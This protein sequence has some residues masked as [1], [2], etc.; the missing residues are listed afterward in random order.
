MAKPSKSANATEAPTSGATEAN[1]AAKLAG[2]VGLLPDQ[3]EFVNLIV[4]HFGVMGELMTLDDALHTYMFEHDEFIAFVSD[5]NVRAALKERDIPVRE[6]SW[7]HLVSV[8][9]ED[10]IVNSE[11]VGVPNGTVG[12]STSS[13]HSSSDHNN[14]DVPG[15]D[16]PESNWKDK[17]LSPL[18][19]IAVNTMLDLIDQRSEKKK[20]QDLGISTV[21]WQ[22]W[23]KDKTFSS[24]LHQ[25]AEAMLGDHQHEAQLALLDKIR[26]GDINAIKYY[27]EMTGKY[28]QQ[29]ASGSGT[30]QLTD[31]KQLLIRILEV[32]DDEVDDPDTAIRIAERFKGLISMQHM[33]NTLIPEPDVASI[34]QP[35]IA[36][37]RPLSP[38]LLALMEKGAGS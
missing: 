2:P 31:F 12:D 33:A 29:T 38:R 26:M 19:L 10:K 35:E 14:V 20:L 25:R 30:T 32:I 9:L 1:L 22:T 7:R 5:A 28:V 18:Q 37:A 8:D 11:A 27:N 21:Q 16:V 4:Q 3:I 13:N 6:S 23:L 15:L 36:Q 24:Y 34:A 17:A